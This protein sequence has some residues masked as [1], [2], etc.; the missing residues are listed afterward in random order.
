MDAVMVNLAEVR[1]TPLVQIV[2]SQWILKGFP[3]MACAL[4]PEP[5]LLLSEYEAAEVLGLND[6][7]TIL[8]D[9]DMVD[10]GEPHVDPDGDIGVAMILAMIEIEHVGG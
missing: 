8:G 6:K 5:V 2:L 10:L 7:D 1:D 4:G 9:D 3:G